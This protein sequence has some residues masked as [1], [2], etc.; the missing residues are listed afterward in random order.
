M[1]TKPNS[2]ANAE[3]SPK[4]QLIQPLGVV[5]RADTS[6]STEGLRDDL[7]DSTHE[8]KAQMGDASQKAG[9]AYTEAKQKSAEQVR[10]L[11][12]QA[13]ESSVTFLDAQ[14]SRIADEVGK[15]SRATRD[16]ADRLKEEDDKTLASY[17]R[18]VA[19]ILDDAGDYLNDTDLSIVSRD[20]Q[21]MTRRHPE[22]VLGGLFVVGLAASRFLKSS[23][24][25]TSSP[26]AVPQAA[27]RSNP[28]IK[29]TAELEL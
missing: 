19:D 3:S 15:V 22:W 4:P 25:R 11:A 5:D 1:P 27:T 12:G 2:S 10:R 24:H 13:K 21:S 18:G 8:A 6:K 26:V 16:A 28:L 14:K 29:P 7:R 9:Q 20:V 23:A 17:A